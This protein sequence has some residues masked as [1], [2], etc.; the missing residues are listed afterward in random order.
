MN[1]P[2]R[3]V[4]PDRTTYIGGSDVAAILGVS[5]WT[6]AFKLYQ[7]KI[8]EFVDE[9]TPAKQKL[10][11]R[12]N[13]WEPIVV[14]MLVDEL[15]DR[16]HDVEII[17]RNQRYRD[18]E[19]PFLAAEIDL[20]L[21]IDGEEVNGEAKTVSPWA[22]KAWGEEETDEV[23]IYY[24]AQVMH[25]L[26]IKPRRRTVIAALTGFD[27]KPRVHWI[28]RDEE[29][30]AGIRA[31]EIEFWERVQNRTPPEPTDPEDVKWLYQRD[32]GTAIE[33]SS[34]I[35]E[36]CQY[37]KD[38]K[39]SA[40]AQEAQIEIVAARIKTFMGTAAVLLGPDGMPLAT[41]KNNKDSIKTDFEAAYRS[42]LPAPGHIKAFTTTK[43]GARPFNL[44]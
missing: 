7:Q 29:T 8:G 41:W 1:A 32:G 37:L 12:G 43:A 11:D 25:G 34:D 15:R 44:K 2:E 21:R 35:V 23:P 28:D 27:D 17:A 39:A 20:E 22:V 9:V 40:K 31:R 30:I 26:M 4:S 42:L 10:F 33:A 5:P 19:F 36:L 38:M 18:P 24:A 3:I 16:G 6:T 13:R 14:E